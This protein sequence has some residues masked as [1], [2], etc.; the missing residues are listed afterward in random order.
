LHE[1]AAPGQA[2]VLVAP[3]CFRGYAGIH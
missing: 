1:N 3:A 2:G